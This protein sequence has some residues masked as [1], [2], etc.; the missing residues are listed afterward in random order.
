MRG[1]ERK[2]GCTLHRKEQLLTAR[3]TADIQ[4]RLSVVRPE[5]TA[6]PSVSQRQWQYREWS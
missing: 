2:N 4:E 6:D 5:R 1:W 3:K